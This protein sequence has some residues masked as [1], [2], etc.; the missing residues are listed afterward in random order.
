MKKSQVDL[1]F[2]NKSNSN[3]VLQTNENGDIVQNGKLLSGSR[4]IRI[5]GGIP[6]FIEV[7]DI[8]NQ[9]QTHSSF[10]FKWINADKHYQNDINNQSDKT[11]DF[12]VETEPIRYGFK[13]IYEMRK[14][15]ES[16]PSILEVGC[17]SGHYTSLFLTS[18]YRGQYV[19]VDLSEG[20]DIAAKRNKSPK[21]FHV[22]A[23]LFDL[24]FKNE[25]FDLIH[26]RGVMHHTPDT[27]KA[28]ESIV[29]HLK[30]NGEFV[31]LIYKK[32]GPIREFTDDFI[33]ESI[34]GVSP[35]EAWDLLLDLAQF[36]KELAK[37]SQKITLD[38]GIRILD[39]PPGEYDLHMLIY[40]HFLKAFYKSDWTLD[41]NNI[42][43]YDWYHP[44]YVFRHTKDEILSWCKE[45]NLEILN[46]DDRWVG[47]TVRARRK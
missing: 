42:I 14:H 1:L 28:F 45:Y 27:K 15:Y 39:I 37:S 9:I 6:R 47:Y 35:S 19:G 25:M 13:N 12:M 40:N 20:V 17:G 16:F 24:P 8:S 29:R 26:C 36:G 7:Q 33:R 32:N 4:E 46:F 44:E 10:S 5:A 3:F 11:F 41:E 38:K 22:Q 31:F 34:K 43:T 21:A 2:D 30:P 23:S 18:D